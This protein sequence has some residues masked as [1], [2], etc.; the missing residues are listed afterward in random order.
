MTDAIVVGGGFAGVA[1]ATALAEGGARVQLLEARPYLG[2]RARSFVDE[3]TGAIVDNGQHLFMGCYV[4][5]RRLLERLG[6]AAGLGLQPRLEVPFLERGGRTVTFSLPPLPSPLDL[7]AGFLKFPGMTWGGRLSLL[8]VAREVARHRD[9]GPGPA[10][11]GRGG[12][13]DDLSVGEWL[14]ALGQSPRSCERFWHPLAIAALNEEP[15]RASAA[16]FLPVLREAFLRGPEG[17]RLGI[18]RVGLS[19]L[20]A[21]PAPHFLR[22]RDGRVRLRAPVREIRLEQGRCVGVRLA[23]GGSID[24]PAVVA[25]VP[26]TELLELLPGAEAEHPFL[27]GLKR[28]ETSPIV[29]IYLWFGGLITG[30]PF[31]GLIGGAWH[32]LFNRGATPAR[33]GAPDCVTLVRSAA[34]GMMDRPRESLERSAL[35][36]LHEFLPESRRVRLRRS[37][38]I[39]EKRATLAPLRGTLGL[40]P[41]S[42]TPWPGLHLAGDWTATGLPATVEGAVLSGHRCAR[43]VLEDRLPA[44]VGERRAAPAVPDA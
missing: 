41:P 14:A 2:G 22:A 3:E 10:A 44:G 15:E 17:S 8:R 27:S 11:A 5:T 43:Q 20:Y 18:P 16:M 26:H 25:A 37:L 40:R 19:Q 38:V 29:S 6:T 30:L 1:A 12:V 35:E 23:D 33:P 32:W 13:L 28:L 42:R 7:A 39:K 31:A 34:R 24:A 21:E 9:G 4:E 36:D